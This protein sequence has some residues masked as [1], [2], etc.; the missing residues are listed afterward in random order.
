MGQE[1]NYGDLSDIQLGIYTTG[2]GPM[3]PVPGGLPGTMIQLE[4]LSN[5]L[6]YEVIRMEH[7]R[8]F[9]ESCEVMWS[10]R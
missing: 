2:I 10:I 8:M 9:Y 6:D 4:R 7:C 1:I 3:I 5:G